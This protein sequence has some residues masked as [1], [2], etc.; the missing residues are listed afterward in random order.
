AE[1]AQR[2]AAL[3]LE[4]QVQVQQAAQLA[5]L[6]QLQQ[7]QQQQ[8]IEVLG[9]RQVLEEVVVNQNGVNR[10]VRRIRQGPA[11]PTLDI[12]AVE[13]QH[14][15]SS[16]VQN[17]LSNDQKQRLLARAAQR[18]ANLDVVTPTGR[19]VTQLDTLLLL[20]APQREKISEL[21]AKTLELPANKTAAQR[22]P[23][24]TPALIDRVIRTLPVD[25]MSAL[26][27]PIQF[28]RWQQ[29]GQAPGAARGMPGVPLDV[30]DA[31]AVHRFSR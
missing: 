19:I 24:V 10:V 31:P 26:L 13:Q 29:W 5:Q 18:S 6:Q 1:W 27:S 3:E 4:A 21:V 30:I 9:Q 15:W 7:L 22:L 23:Q 20:D 11:A 12:T 2:Q 16:A 14:V 8:R 28:A 17:T 25:E